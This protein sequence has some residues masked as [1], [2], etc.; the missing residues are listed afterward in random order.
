MSSHTDAW[1]V[2]TPFGP[3]VVDFPEEGPAI[4][5]GSGLA[6]DHLMQVMGERTN[7]MGQTMTAANLEPHDLLFFCQGEGVKVLPPADF[8]PPQEPEENMNFATLDNV[9]DESL[10][11]LRAKLK[12]T[13]GVRARLAVIGQMV[14]AMVAP[15]DITPQP[16]E[17]TP[18]QKKSLSR[19]QKDNNAAIEMLKRIRAGEANP[20]DPAVREALK[21]YSGSGG[22][23]TSATGL[24]GSPTEYYTPKPV[25][26]AV[27]GLLTGLGFAGGKVLDPS[28]GMGIFAQTKPAN[29]AVEQCEID[30]ISGEITGYLNN[31]DTVST[32][33]SSFEA[34][35]ASTD[36]ETHDAVVTNVPFGDFAMRGGMQKHD[37]KYQKASLT[38]YF[39]LRTLDKVRPGGYAALIV[40]SGVVSG[41]GGKS[42]NLRMAASLK[43]EFIGAYRL[44]NQVFDEAGAD[45]ITDV[46]IFRKHGKAQ[47]AKI[48]EL[49][50]QNPAI[51]KAALVLWDEFLSGNYFKLSGKR[52]QIGE[53][54]MGMGRFGEVEKVVHTGDIASVA[55]LMRPFDKGGRIDWAMLDTVET[56]PIVYAEG[57]MIYSGGLTLQ[58]VDG[59]LTPMEGGM[60]NE[61]A[62]AMDI[63]SKL[64]SPMDCLRQGVTLDDARRVLTHE[65]MQGRVGDLPRWVT[66][67]VR[68]AAT[69]EEFEAVV[70]GLCVQSIDSQ[71]ATESTN[72]QEQYPEL[73]AAIARTW[74]IA[75]KKASSAPA[76]IAD[77]LQSMA[78]AR[79]KTGFTPW[80]MGQT[81]QG[82]EKALLPSQAYERARMDM[83]VGDEW[84][85][86]D[87]MR[88]SNPDF[89]PI[90]DAA[91]C[92]SPDGQGV[93]HP[94]DY[95]V[96]GYAD[97][98][99]RAKQ[100][101]EAA[102]DP[103][104]RQ[105]L[106]LQHEAATQRLPMVDVSKMTFTLESSHVSK[107][108]ILLF[109][110]Q[111][112][113]SEIDLTMTAG[114]KQVFSYSGPAGKSS[115]S[116]D[117]LLARKALQRFIAYLNEGTITTNNNRAQALDDPK[118]ERMHLDV[119]KAKV[120][121]AN[122]QFDS[123]CKASD[124]GDRV[125]ARL[126]SPES[127]RF[128]E[129]PD[130]APLEIDGWNPERKP[131]DYQSA[132]AR[133]FSKRFSGII[134]LDV[135][136]GKTLTALATV[137]Y[138]QSLGTKK[139]TIFAVPNSV[140]TNWK[141]E[142]EMSYTDISDCLFVG[143]ADNGKYNSANV[144]D[145]LASIVSGK[146]SKIFMTFETLEKIPLRQET[147]DAYGQYLVANDDAFI[148]VVK[149]DEQAREARGKASDAISQKSAIEKAISGGKKSMA[150][151]YFEDMGVDSLV[152]DEC[153]AFKNS[154]RYSTG[155]AQTKFVANPNF[156][157]RGRAMQA[158]CWY[159]RGMTPAQDGIMALTA[160][161]VTNS[162]LEIYAMLSLAV[163]E[164]EV[165]AMCG[166][167]GADS[168][169]NNFCGVETQSEENII[170]ELRE[171]RTLTGIDN[172]SL[173]RRV[174]DS[175]CVIETVDTVAKRGTKIEV[176]EYEE[177]SV[178]VELPPSFKTMLMDMTQEYKDLVAAK[179]AGGKLS[180]AEA[181]K[182]SPFNLIRRMTK[183]ITDR[184]LFEGEFRYTFGKGQED[185]ANAAVTAFNKLKITEE[186]KEYEIPESVDLSG[187]KSKM[188]TDK[189]TGAETLIYFVPVTARIE[190]RELVIPGTDFDTHDKMAAIIEKAGITL[191]AKASP[192]V[193]ALLDNIKS[194]NA[195]PRWSKPKQIVF[196]DE[197]ALHHKLR[198]LIASETGVPAS[199]IAIVNG[200]SVNPEQMQVI[201]DGFNADGDKDSDEPNLYQII[202]ANKKAEVGINLQK[203]TQAIHH[204]TIGWTPD[205]IHQRNGRGVRQGNKI[206]TPIV[207]YHYDAN[208]TFDSYKRHLVSVKGDWIGQVMDQDSSSVQIAGDLS[209]EDYERLIAA[210]GDSEAM[211][212]IMEE[213]A[214]KAKENLIRANMTAQA[215]AL[216]NMK[217]SA[218]WVD[219]FGADYN[220]G[221]WVATKRIAI[222]A[223]GSQINELNERIDKT[224][225]HDV[226]RR[227]EAQIAE[228][229]TRMDAAQAYIDVGGKTV[230]AG[231]RG[232]DFEGTTAFANW[233]KEVNL[234]T[235]MRDEAENN[236]RMRDGQGYTVQTLEAFKT[237]SA[238]AFAGRIIARGDLIVTAD[239]TPGMVDSISA[240]GAGGNVILQP[241]SDY[242]AAQLATVAIAQHGPVGTPA[243]A[244]ILKLIAANC[245]VACVTE[246]VR[247]GLWSQSQEV[248][249]AMTVAAPSNWVELRSVVFAPPL[250]PLHLDDG[251]P[252]W[253]KEAAD[254]VAESEIKE[255]G[256][257]TMIRLRDMRKMGESVQSV[258]ARS[259]LVHAWLVANHRAMDL[260]DFKVLGIDHSMPRDGLMKA[261]D[262]A[263]AKA[264]TMD[265]MGQ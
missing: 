45:V 242:Q 19:R 199:K 33:I 145:D 223:M 218:D 111:Y 162:P 70:A 92:V 179:K 65:T 204:L 50:Q 249:E 171:N 24:T 230:G 108:E 229:Q 25:A 189:E 17:V 208:G 80:W 237:G 176:P 101:L 78:K 222:S 30:Q 105:K 79:N 138:V 193:L 148:K 3:V 10:Q 41:K 86:V 227:C 22:G 32:V 195:N 93:M 205:S 134:G 197:L 23:L 236:F 140:L 241:K 215:N 213:S 136:L 100:E 234:N 170:G 36:D 39:V 180:Q 183:L 6:V 247:S 231:A 209:R 106:V 51:L 104:V 233:S 91:W 4:F 245:D 44:P 8:I 83:E 172:L 259:S 169:M 26:H 96:G 21:G 81:A 254:Q 181:I 57:D 250:F 73:S 34:L 165:N 95:Y 131:H 71:R 244:E 87:V 46:I 192:K 190:G 133:R 137:Q 59:K 156:S 153:H 102:T 48:E 161:P 201:Q 11:A 200:Q 130:Y 118:T 185:K 220:F 154:K 159:L 167:T 255:E 109:V 238:V 5:E 210:N 38:D 141:K 256:W 211:A 2:I 246:G 187:F 128:I 240:R 116:P 60:T 31:S 35:A 263:K 228:I 224:E 1:N 191:K 126:N 9:G 264:K 82:E 75:K 182:A 144:N 64:T 202:I 151:P 66:L 63:L 16:P 160:T 122:S 265:D 207:I 15:A 90:N 43:A 155:F 143:L 120:A 55:A 251:N 129:E 40:S 147:L 12:T 89:D 139:R 61:D 135:G 18:E 260:V 114:G 69:A 198:I 94:R 107:D 49:R 52:Y 184:E 235:R 217:A 113:S 178:D 257:R 214:A 74:K 13:A 239:G 194:E 166:C 67:S 146:Y 7:R 168:F 206:D 84:V 42:A 252:K 29:V 37:P 99:A 119:I 175:S 77:A 158:K 177:T 56:A 53:S 173:I 248:R 253:A 164:K 188:V 225:S 152:I 258:S 88:Q 216:T 226:V 125:R 243:R 98:L 219:K 212:R 157:N 115:D 76:L 68:N 174:L 123:W 142:A 121:A 28:A 14:A 262:E 103:A 149:E 132:T 110:K 150:V 221:A 27:W 112:V 72:Y 97:F 232:S 203:G 117:V 85:S 196:C 62:G 127:L 124:I 163:G 261:I 47:A 54:T 20:Q 186:R 58:F